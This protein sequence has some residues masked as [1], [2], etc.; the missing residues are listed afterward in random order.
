MTHSD[1]VYK[2]IIISLTG[3]TVDEADARVQGFV[4]P[5]D[6]TAY[7]GYDYRAATM[8]SSRKSIP[9][10]RF[11]SLCREYPTESVK[12]YRNGKIQTVRGGAVFVIPETEAY[13]KMLDRICLWLDQVFS[14]V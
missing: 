2:T 4:N 8:V 10:P 11:G 12:L 1:N 7:L 14:D 3:G 5:A 9:V 6:I 13:N